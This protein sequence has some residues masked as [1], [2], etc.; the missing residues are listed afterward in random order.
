MK[1]IVL[2]LWHAN[3][4]LSYNSIHAELFL[5]HSTVWT[6]TNDHPLPK[7]TYISI[8]VCHQWMMVQ[9]GCSDECQRWL[10]QLQSSKHLCTIIIVWRRLVANKSIICNIFTHEATVPGYPAEQVI[11]GSKVCF[12]EIAFGLLS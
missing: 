9:Y 8:L 5:C 1:Q 12:P 11:E 6:L 7:N 4:L 3:Y 10:K 2:E